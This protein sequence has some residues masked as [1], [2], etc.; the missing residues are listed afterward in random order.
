MINIYFS[1]GVVSKVV[2]SIMKGSSGVPED[3][4]RAVVK[5]WLISEDDKINAS[6]ET[7]VEDGKI[8][9]DLS[10]VNH[11]IDYPLLPA[12]VYSMKALWWKDENMQKLSVAEVHN[13]FAVTS[14]QE[15]ATPFT[16]D[17]LTIRVKSPAAT[18]GYDGLSAYEIACMRGTTTALSEK[19]YVQVL[20]IQVEE[21]HI[22]E[23]AITT[24]KLADGAVT[25]D[26]I[27]DFD[28][29]A[30][31]QTGVTTDKLAD[32]AVTT[33]K[34]ADTSVTTDKVVDAAVTTPKIADGAVT[35]AKILDGNVTR[36]KINTSAVATEK[37]A[38]EAV[39]TAKIA[40]GAVTTAKLADGSVTEDKLADDAV[41]T[42]KIH[43]GAVTTGKIENSAITTDKL[44]DA[45]IT[46]QKIANGTLTGAKFVDGSIT[47]TKIADN[48]V[49][50]SKL[51]DGTITGVDL[52]DNS[53][54]GRKLVDSSVDGVKI[55]DGAI[56]SRHLKDNSIPAEKIKDG[57][58]ENVDIKDGTLSGEKVKDNTIQS[59]KFADGAIG[60][61]K[62]VDNSVTTD[63]LDSGAVTAAK[64][65]DG[66]VTSGKINSGAVTTGKIA[67]EA[68]TEDKL[69]NGAVTTDKLSDG[70]IEEIQTITDAE[71]TSG[72]VKP[73][74]SGGVYNELALGAVYDVSAKNPTAGSNSDGKWESLSALLSD[75]NLSIL[76]PTS[77]RKG[78]MSI[79]FI[80]SSDNKYVQ[81]RLMSDTFNTT[82]ANW[83]GVDDEPTDGSDN[84]V[85]SG[86]IKTALINSDDYFRDFIIEQ[87][88]IVEHKEIQFEGIY[89]NTA[90]INENG[91][92]ISQTNSEWS[93]DDYYNIEDY[94]EL[95]ISGLYATQ[96]QIIAYFTNDSNVIID[97][98]IG[99]PA[100][101][102]YSS[103][104]PSGATRIYFNKPPKNVG[105]KYKIYLIRKCNVYGIDSLQVKNDSN[106]ENIDTLTETLFTNK[107]IVYK[108]DADFL[109]NTVNGHVWAYNP[110]VVVD[111]IMNGFLKKSDY[112]PYTSGIINLHQ[113]VSNGILALV[114][115]DDE[116]SVTGYLRGNGDSEYSIVPPSGTTRIYWS[117]KQEDNPDLKNVWLKITDSLDIQTRISNGGLIIVPKGVY[118]FDNT[119]FV[120]SNTRII[121]QY[122][123][124]VFKTN[125]KTI[126][127]IS[128]N[129][130]N[131]CIDGI[132]FVG[133]EITNTRGKIQ[134]CSELESEPENNIL[135]TEFETLKTN[136][137][138][139]PS[140]GVVAEFAL[141]GWSVM[142]PIPIDSSIKSIVLNQHIDSGQRCLYCTTSD[143]TILKIVSGDGSDVYVVNIPSGTEYLYWC[144]QTS[145]S[146]TISINGIGEVTG[147]KTDCGIYIHNGAY[148][149]NISNCVFERF[150]KTGIKVYQTL[151]NGYRF[152]P[153]ISQCRFNEN[154]VGII[155]AERA[156]FATLVNCEFTR[157]QI[158]IWTCASNTNIGSCQI[159]ANWC[160]GLVMVGGYENSIHT[161]VSNCEI[162]HNGYNAGNTGTIHKTYDIAF[163]KTTAGISIT[164]CLIGIDGIIFYQAYGILISSCQL[165]CP[166]YSVSPNGYN[167]VHDNMWRKH[168]SLATVINGDQTYLSLK[169]N[170]YTSGGYD[171]INN[172]V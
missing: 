78:G 145:M 119:I 87:N 68:V 154:F 171:N 140:N 72:S 55:A 80:Q 158:G 121:G 22:A 24:P 81:Y 62:I 25:T 16:G 100:S 123:E 40:D 64:I 88:N 91:S 39:T 63:K 116:E 148:N 136:F 11:S 151:I 3:F 115:S 165:I 162:V 137:A 60:T 15:E 110:N 155:F 19:E 95:I 8:V 83:Q 139:V 101:S 122:G 67:D 109:K 76:I 48:T 17:E 51:Q 94:T 21:V 96:V 13:A 172:N 108:L 167:M 30:T 52:Q 42:D 146:G 4:S 153:K 38:N 34:I 7:T 65:V 53:L 89:E 82:V 131:V 26:K 37:I 92:V 120:P 112:I 29:S 44:H 20:T 1:Q 125:N 113:L 71:P 61:S 69:A 58:I 129:T 28:D 124:V 50:G 168:A 142:A 152:A 23:Q 156:E 10:A 74:Q 90:W 5:V 166:I 54:P 33:P 27:Q 114:F 75:A 47:G 2:W 45:A 73:V 118:E 170:R 46:N 169:N 59:A 103:A 79:K 163:I 35:T 150:G 43:D 12:N 160:H 159:S 135:T 97:R 107:S 99:N 104:I 134:T 149:V 130:E 31:D 6:A 86:G 133:G 70:M 98:I 14:Y 138:Y 147:T 164:G 105:S 144:C 132:K 66:A 106:S 41:T 9:I 77:V 36:D 102:H 85:K 49:P 161:V 117:I 143:G 111:L 141:N 84:L 18:Y 127:E 93:C 32:S 57:T 56:E 126:L 128:G 157:N